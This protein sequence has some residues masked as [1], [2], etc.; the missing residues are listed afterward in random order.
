MTEENPPTVE[1]TAPE[2]S[3][4][5]KG[6]DVDYVQSWEADAPGRHVMISALTHGNELCGAL[7]VERLLKMGVRP[8]RGRLTLAFINVAAFTLFDPDDPYASRFI[9]EDFN[10][11]WTEE[12]LD[13]DDNSVE[14][15]RAR[16]L[17]EVFDSV[18]D[19][20]DIHSMST[21]SPPL[22]LTHDHP[23][24]VAMARKV[25]Y[26]AYVAAGPVFAPGKRI[27]EYTPFADAANDKTALLVECGQH[28]AVETADV[29]M[30]TALRFL[31]ATGVMT[32][33]EAGPH[34]T[35]DNP[36]APGVYRVTD[37]ITPETKEFRFLE[38]YVGCEVFPK[39]GTP[40]ADDGGAL[41]TTP[42]DDCM[43][44]MPNH[45]AG[46]GQRAGRFAR[47]IAD[48]FISE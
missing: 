28:W 36:P 47:F 48:G 44:V 4:Y 12:R 32:A 26:P 42:Y 1:L 22:I 37:G 46:Q 35:T 41:V 15:R 3:S 6:P 17:R 21:H 30:E 7:A 25:G 27:I 16:K 5:R 18:D 10:R 40:V 8:K 11:L 14:L 23:K 20:L 2:I 34:L 39:A 43:L 29:A 33:E 24:H 9:D 45:R 31:M 38:D 13:G 19:L